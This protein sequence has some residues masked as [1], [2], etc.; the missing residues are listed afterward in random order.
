MS[1]L[2]CRVARGAERP[3]GPERGR[4]RDYAPFQVALHD[5]KSRGGYQW[6]HLVPAP[7]DQAWHCAVGGRREV[8]RT[9]LSLRP[10]NVWRRAWRTLRC[11]CRLLSNPGRKSGARTRA[12]LSPLDRN[13]AWR[14]KRPQPQR[15]GQLLNRGR[16]RGRRS[17]GRPAGAPRPPAPKSCLSLAF[18][19]HM[20]PFIDVL[21]GPRLPAIACCAV[22]A[23]RNAMCTPLLWLSLR[24]GGEL[25]SSKQWCASSDVHF[26][27]SV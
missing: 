22:F 4:M 10:L 17:R 9:E 1:Q 20:R 14:R 27:P 16:R 13:G 6:W 12:A 2:A 19:V 3:A 25:L 5:G 15:A 7:I 11:A 21:S 26:L 8:V 18:R 23:P 24:L